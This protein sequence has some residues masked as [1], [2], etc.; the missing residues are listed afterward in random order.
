MAHSAVEHSAVLHAL[1]WR[2]DLR[3]RP[4]PV[5]SLGRVDLTDLGEPDVVA[6][7]SAN[8]EVGTLQPVGRAAETGRPVFMDAG[9]SMGR[10][11]LPEGWSVA[12][13]ELGF[14]Q[15]ANSRLAAPMAATILSGWRK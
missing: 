13:L 14:E 9:A 6:V 11:P 15:P 8:H 5:D 7:Q 1:A 10:L 2:P 4:I 3:V 12:V